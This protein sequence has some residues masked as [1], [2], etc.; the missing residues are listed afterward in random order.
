MNWTAVLGQPLAVRLLQHAVVTG[1]LAHAYLFVGPDGVG[2][3]T[4]ARVL[5]KTMVCR[6]RSVEGAPCGECPS[7]IKADVIPS[8]H[9]DIRFVEPEG[10]L[11][12]TD[13]IRALQAEMYAR[14]TEG[15]TRIAIIDEV[16]HMNAEAGNRILK[17]LEEP[18][19]YALLV[20]LTSNLAGVLPTIVSR[21]QVVN[22][23]PV[24]TENIADILAARG[25]TP[26]A[27]R[28]LA[29]LSGGSI[30]RA[31]A[32]SEDADLTER[33]EAA[34]QTVEQL[35]RCDDFEVISLSES[36]EKQR[37]S[38]DERLEWALLFFRDAL[39]T[40][41][42]DS[43]SLLINRDKQREL[44][45]LGEAL[46]EARLIQMLNI[47]GETRQRLQRNANVRLALDVMLLQLAGVLREPSR[48]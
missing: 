42:K 40:T 23:V 4:V 14:P 46:G 47:V 20:L 13:Q 9:P 21:C 1:R 32:L 41:Q 28:L 44:T 12:K 24:S 43:E 7:C 26:D 15:N 2:K 22:F 18:P 25:I 31:V 11:V 6:T 33:R 16:D 30:G 5:A 29:S 19:S 3:R 39:L 8:V 45:S 48:N 27:S 36:L 34:L 37:E 10:R 38:L 35:I 17:L